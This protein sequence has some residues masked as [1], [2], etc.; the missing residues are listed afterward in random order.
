MYERGTQK[1]KVTLFQNI[2]EGAEYSS[3]GHH[4]CTH[5]NQFSE[6]ST[7][8]LYLATESSVKVALN[9]IRTPKQE[10]NYACSLTE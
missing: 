3:I 8:S 2:M 9:S 4:P 7:S 6:N 1:K 10:T 5:W